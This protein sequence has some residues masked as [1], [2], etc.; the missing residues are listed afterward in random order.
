MNLDFDTGSADLWVFST[1]LPSSE[2]SGQTLYD[3]SQSST[4][5]EL[6]G[7]T[8]NITYGDGSSSSGNVYTDTVTI[9]GLSVTGQAVELAEQVSAQFVQD[10]ANDG[11]LGLAFSSI[12]TVMPDQQTTFFDT[13]ISEGLLAANVFTADLQAGKP[14]SYDFGFIDSSKYSG[15]IT[16][17]G[18][19]AIL[20]AALAYMN[21]TNTDRP[22]TSCRYFSRF[23]GVHRLR[24]RHR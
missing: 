7:E 24:I 23:L 14:G 6:Q 9:G 5:Q 20:L 21:T 2:S 1:E 16:Y 19:L 12:N 18:K 17:A 3:P 13:A 8:W 10:T 22:T 15:S 4:A 11:L